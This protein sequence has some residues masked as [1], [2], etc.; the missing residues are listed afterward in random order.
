MCDHKD[1]GGKRNLPLNVTNPDLAS[2]L[3]DQSLA[4]K[5]SKSSPEVVQWRCKKD[6]RHIYSTSVRQRAISHAGCNICA[7]KVV[8]PGLNDLATTHPDIARQLVNKSVATAVTGV[9][10]ATQ[11]WQCDLGHQWEATVSSRTGKKSGCPYCSGDLVIPGQTDMATTHPELAKQLVCTDPTTIKAGT[12]K[13]LRWRCDLGH[14]WV[15]P[16]HARLRGDGCP[17]CGRKKVLAGFNDMLTTNPDMAA[18]LVGDDPTKFLAGTMKKLR[19]RCDL[20][21]EWIAT[22]NDRLTGYGCPCCSGKKAWPGESDMLTTHPHLAE[23]LV[24]TDPR[25]VKAGTAKKLKWRC[26]K[27]HIW[28]AR[29]SERLAGNGCS[30]C[31]NRTVVPGV[32]DMLTLR[33][34][35]AGELMDTDPST[36]SVGTNRKLRWRCEKGHEWVATA[37]ARSCENGTG[38]PF[39]SNKKVLKGYNDMLTVR[40]DLARDLVGTDPSTVAAGSAR[41]LRWRCALGHEWH[42][43]CSDR[44]F[45]NSTCPYCAYKKL[46]PGFNCLATT[47]PHIAEM[48]V[49]RDPSTLMA[50]SKEVQRWR[51]KDGH[52]W[53]APTVRLFCGSGCP[54]CA[55]TG[56]DQTAPS[57]IYLVEAPGKFKIGV[58]NEGTH[59]LRQ[60]KYNG[61]SLVDSAAGD[62]RGIARLELVIKRTLRSSGVFTGKRAF[63]EPFDGWTESWNSADLA[64]SSIRELCDFLGIDLDAFLAA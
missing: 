63:R 23:Q 25:T 48:L 11:L 30:V 59:R 7:G 3:V 20:G 8:V 47:H 62:G 64:V 39:C 9:S 29:G 35:L 60:H 13:K 38:C 14:E 31:A 1:C 49:G 44:H 22:G 36:V 32:N 40:P 37:C 53:M 42:A 2:E 6:Q 56:F 34:D 19:W 24:D 21:H 61:W 15:A 41:K 46:L 5:L 10:N 55:K 54:A 43:K 50:G 4:G 57:V 27:G 33:P 52:E 26:E 16:G 18:Q 12:A 17:V 58:M 51:C 45:K 28:S